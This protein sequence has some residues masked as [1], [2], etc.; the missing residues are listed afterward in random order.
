MLTGLFF[1]YN[2]ACKEQHAPAL[3]PLNLFYVES[4]SYIESCIGY[5]YYIIMFV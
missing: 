3:L 4:L 2:P 5:G 1:I